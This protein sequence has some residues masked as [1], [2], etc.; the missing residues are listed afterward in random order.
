VQKVV[1]SVLIDLAAEHPYHRATVNALQHA[2][3]HLRLTTDIRIVRTDAIDD[4]DGVVRP[5]TAIVIGPGSPYRNKDAAHAIVRAARERGVPL[6][7][8]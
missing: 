6:V 8:T 2:S 3:S 1:V 7:G 4:V 5:G